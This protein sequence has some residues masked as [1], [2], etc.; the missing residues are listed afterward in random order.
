M[1]TDLFT[2]IANQ[3]ALPA[4]SRAEAVQRL[5]SLLYEVQQTQV[6]QPANLEA[7]HE[8]DQR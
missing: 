5:A 3:T 7:G 8:Q 2:V 6:R 4:V 1:Q